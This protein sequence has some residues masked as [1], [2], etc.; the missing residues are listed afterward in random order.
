MLVANGHKLYFYTRYNA[1]KRRNDIEIDFLLT[2]GSKVKQKLIPIEVKSAKSF[3]AESLQRFNDKFKA[4][5][6]VSYIIHPKNLMIR[7]DGGIICLPAY[8]TFCL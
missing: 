8:M 6:D 4:R 3:K 1:E 2:T 7:D 5:I